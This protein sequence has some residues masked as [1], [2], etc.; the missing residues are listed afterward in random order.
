MGCLDEQTVI[1]FVNGRLTGQALANA[2]Q[3]L[4]TCGDCT[5]LVALAAPP[6]PGERA[7][8]TADTA[9][10]RRAR[11]P[12]PPVT[13]P[14]PGAAVGRYRLLHLVG[15]GGMGEVYAAHDPELDRKVAIKILRADN[16][17]D[18]VE[19]ARLLREAQSV[20]KLS[21]PNLVTVYDVGTAG[22]RLFLA[23]ELIEGETLAAWLAAERRSRP[24]IVRVFAAAGRGLAAAHRA[25]VV[26]RDFKP[27]NVMVAADGTPRVMDFGLAA[28]DQAASEPR[29]TRLGAILG[30]PLYMAPEQLRGLPVDARADQFS[31]CVTLYEAL[32][33]ERPFAG[34]NFP[35]LR[36]AVLGGR[37]RPAPL[38]SGVPRRVR[39]A[40]LRGLSVD[41]AR[42][43]PD[44]DAL[45]DAIELGMARG[46]RLAPLLVGAGAAGA[47]ALAGVLVWQMRAPRPATSCAERPQTLDVAWPKRAN[48]ARRADVRAA[49]VSST[50]PDARERHARA[51]QVLDAYADAWLNVHRAGCE[52][53]RA[54]SEP[55]ALRAARARCLD[56]RA[57]ALG[58]LVDVFAHADAKTVRRSIPSALALPPT[59][60][61]ADAATLKASATVPDEPAA[62]ARLAPLR[63]RLAALRAL[64][65]AG[66]DAQAL[67][68]LAALVEEARGSG[69]EAL[70]A[71]A[72]LVHART[73]APFDPE[74]AAAIYE[75][76]FKRGES[77]RNNELAA[78]AAIQMVAIV[79]AIQ[80]RF[81]DGERWARLAESTLE[82]GAPPRL[83][84]WFL[85]NR[86]TLHSARGRWRLA[87]GDFA[88]A[89]AVRQ[90]AA[91]TAQP[92]L[93]ASMVH[94]ARAALALDDPQRALATA[95]RALAIAGG[96]FP[97]DSFEVASARL[98]RGRALITLDRAAEARV[99]LEAVMEIFQSLLGRDHPFLAEPMT[100]LGEV[101][102][103]EGRPRDAQAL[104][105]RAWDMRS[106]H[107][108]DAG[109]REETAFNLARALWESS[110]ADRRHAVELAAEA[111]DGYAVTPDLAPRLAVVTRWLAGRTPARGVATGTPRQR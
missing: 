82:R 43:F 58:A 111:R 18:E 26:H 16:Y 108:A 110:P 62:V 4:L 29:L 105:E 103:V 25:A 49:F 68:P 95:E 67:K 42:R 71:D 3:H 7:T 33:G 32:Y 50:V 20:A 81:T 56:Q 34:E 65:A 14:G 98:I 79:G 45:V 64:A 17:P 84:G 36:T 31:F 37:V 100:G 76:A 88:G 28:L 55:P 89:V 40:L 47:L 48:A 97:A 77:L 63:R 60:A 78:E 90:Q 91:A 41:R 2:E 52:A 74:A 8:P 21:H 73:R 93:A 44:M 5:A 51:S 57:E 86:G 72:L 1:A 85:H 99:D 46:V 39:A 27:Q 9:A 61:C 54:R 11:A 24:E 23:M 104:L 69:D 107:T 12:E 10:A 109:A 75:D 30:T 15:R 80:H 87:E 13:P 38:A 19:S 66:H 102:L 59:D 83:R 94:L 22:G 6:P 35:Q 106:T 101:A 70:L 96:I 53:A 92:E